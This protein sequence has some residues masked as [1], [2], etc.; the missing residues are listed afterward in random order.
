MN[1]VLAGALAILFAVGVR[2]VLRGGRA[3]TWGPIL[4][5]AFGIGMIVAG[6]FPPDPALGFPIGA[7]EGPPKSMSTAAAMHMV[8]FFGAFTA[9]IA[10]CFVFARRFIGHAKA[11]AVY[12][13]VTGLSAPALI[14]AGTAVFAAATG[15]FYLAVGVVMFT[16]LSAVAARLLTR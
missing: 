15:I 5:V 2:V 11:W 13:I 8:G 9:L 3:G 4:I 12:S 6:V 16:W 14:I 10:A 7:P 1:F